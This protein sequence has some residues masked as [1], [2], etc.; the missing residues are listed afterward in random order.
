MGSRV[1]GISWATLFNSGAVGALRSLRTL[2]GLRPLR[3][4]SRFPSMQL[5]IEALVR[6]LPA[7]G[8]VILILLVFWLVFAICG[9]QI[10]GGALS[11]CMLYVPGPL[12][13]RAVERLLVPMTALENRSICE[14]MAA[15]LDA[16]YRLP[17]PGALG[18]AL[19]GGAI[20][21]GSLCDPSG[22]GP[23]PSATRCRLLWHREVSGFDNVGEALLTLTEVATLQGWSRIMRTAMAA[24]G[25][26]LAATHPMGGANPYVAGIYFV[27]FVLVGGFMLIKL[28]AGVVIDKFNRLRDVRSGSAFLSDEQK[29]WVETRWLVQRTR[30]LC[31]PQVPTSPPRRLAFLL[32]SHRAFEIFVMSMIILNVA[33]MAADS[34]SY[35]SAAE[36]DFEKFSAGI[37][38]FFSIFFIVEASIKLYA[39]GV[40]G[41]FSVAW[42]CFD[43]FLCLVSV[44]DFVAEGNISDG[45]FNPMLLRLLRMFRILRLIR[46][47]RSA[48]G[49]RTLLLTIARCLPALGIIC[50]LL[51]LLCTIFATIGMAI[52]GNVIPQ[53]HHGYGGQWAGRRSTT[54]RTRCC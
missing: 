27:V 31:R 15:E 9:V 3:L 39:L 26:D 40:R 48:K 5:V 36:T 2:R 30:P 13:G 29:E 17:M 20:A 43:F 14:A 51:F 22:M 28:F 1:V 7:I 8:N 4:I 52:F 42:N 11:S 44:L 25:Q 21:N 38:F 54:S 35:P 53:P 45:A 37:E 50:S 24:K 23:L 6:A 12:A 46:L 18:D 32:V 49:L 47:V 19:G 16:A 34:Y 41:F 33:M 10:F